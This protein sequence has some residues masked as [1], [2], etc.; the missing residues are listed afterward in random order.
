MEVPGSTQGCPYT[1]RHVAVDMD[2]LKRSL[3]RYV[4]NS[5]YIIEKLDLENMLLQHR[6]YN[7]AICPPRKQALYPSTSLVKEDDLADSS[8]S[9]S[10]RSEEKSKPEETSNPVYGLS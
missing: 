9:L 8:K 4:I 1:M 3:S 2:L 5:H 6:S 10:Q 7:S